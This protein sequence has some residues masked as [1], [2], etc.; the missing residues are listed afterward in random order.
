MLALDGLSPM[1]SAA[2]QSAALG[3]MEGDAGA[4]PV[5]FRQILAEDASNKRSATTEDT[6]CSWGFDAMP[7]EK[8][9]GESVY[10]L[11][12]RER[13]EQAQ[14]KELE[15]I[16]EIEA[17][18]AALEVVEQEESRASLS[19][20]P[21]RAVGAKP[22]PKTRGG[23][24]KLADSSR[25]PADN[26]G[27]ARSMWNHGEGSQWSSWNAHRWPRDT[28]QRDDWKAAGWQASRDSRRAKQEEGSWKGSQWHP[29]G[30]I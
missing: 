12:D 17:M 30:A 13:E 7:S 24:G 25:A 19:P 4:L 9:R 8:P 26:K 18:F 15:D 11:Q 5:D 27:S 1:L 22:K 10:S 14:L 6:K 21:G 20:D 3:E 23:D 2:V 28:W 16:L 29:R